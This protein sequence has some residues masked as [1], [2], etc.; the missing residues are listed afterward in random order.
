MYHHSPEL[1]REL[2]RGLM[3]IVVQ[4]TNRYV[5]SQDAIVKHN[6]LCSMAVKTKK[7]AHKK[8]KQVNPSVNRA[9]VVE[10]TKK[11]ANE[12][13]CKQK[14]QTSQSV[15]TVNRAKVVESIGKYWFQD[16]QD[17]THL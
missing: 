6:G 14:I 9:K 13:K 17:E 1:N 7:S 12:K 5:L 2:F 11:S 15:S 4:Q 3:V 16:E 8:F 10:K